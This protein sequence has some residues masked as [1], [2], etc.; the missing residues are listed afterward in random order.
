[1]LSASPIKIPIREVVKLYGGTDWTFL[2]DRKTILVGEADGSGILQE[3]FENSSRI[4]I[5]ILSEFRLEKHKKVQ[6]IFPADLG[7]SRP[8]LIGIKLRK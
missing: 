3:F 7:G 2:Q 6:N 5:K 1:M 4:P 8:I